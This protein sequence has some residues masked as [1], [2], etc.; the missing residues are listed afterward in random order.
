MTLSARDQTPRLIRFCRAT[1]ADV[2]S[3]VSLVDAAYRGEGL[4]GWTTEAHLVGVRRTDAEA[5]EEVLA[6]PESMV[7]LA[8]IDG[9][10]VGCSQLTKQSSC[11]VLGMLAVRPELQG[12]GIGGAIIGEA[13]RVCRDEFGA[14]EIRMQVLHVRHDIITWYER[15]GYKSNGERIPF[16]YGDERV[17]VPKRNDLEFVVLM[18]VLE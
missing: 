15:L 4:G 18:K 7:I 2:E 13:E 8:R 5:V 11:P 1:R 16:P 17:G 12:R 9:D 10:L 3:I 14:K 6:A